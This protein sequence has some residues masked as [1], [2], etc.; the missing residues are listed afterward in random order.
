MTDSSHHPTVQR[1]FREAE[2][3]LV[4]LPS[5]RHRL[6]RWGTGTPLLFVHGMCGPAH[7]FA[8]EMESLVTA[9]FSCL[10]Y[11]LSGV[12]PQETPC[13]HE[14]YVDD[15][16]ALVDQLQLAP[17]DVQG[18]SFGST[19]VLAAAARSPSAFRRLILQGAFAYRPTR[20]WQHHLTWP[21]LSVSLP[22]QSLP[23]F[24]ALLTRG[25]GQA[26]SPLQQAE[27]VF[28]R[29]CTGEAR[30]GDVARRVHMLHALDLRSCLSQ[31]TQPVLLIG[32]DRDRLVP[33]ACEEVVRA[34]LPA[35]RRVCLSGAGHYPQ[36][37]HAKEMA[38]L[39]RD[40]LCMR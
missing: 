2:A 37:T 3:S 29:R 16:L 11:D 24:H 38:A 12:D 9:G 32:G 35:A 15:L 39:V 8:L 20:W 1:F 18:A 13:T 26:F 14:A 17:V 33:C 21:L 10:A 27:C 36:F 31:I 22:F 19:I 30:A 4:V 5:G 23:L 28:F 34:G 40:A 25:E 6:W 7:S